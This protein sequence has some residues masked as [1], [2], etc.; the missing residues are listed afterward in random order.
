MEK[1]LRC[2]FEGTTTGAEEQ[3]LYVFFRND[4]VPA[5]LLEYKSFFGYVE[6]GMPG[7]LREIGSELSEY[8]N[9]LPA[10]NHRWLW[11]GV[12]ASLLLF[13]AAGALLLN[14]KAAFDPYEGSYIVRNGV[15]ITD[16]DKVRPE[17]ERTIA[18]VLEKKQEAEALLNSINGSIQTL[19]LFEN[20]S[21]NINK[22]L[23]SSF[24]EG[25][26]QNEVK[27]ILENE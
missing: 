11:M 15:R 10:K 2:F 16:P 18:M 1:L 21:D 7:E 4:D 25:H 24:P 3:T 9:Q 17:V 12:A 27:R 19:H 6:G 20:L 23:L 26:V 14:T 5:H 8:S 13:I 22:Q